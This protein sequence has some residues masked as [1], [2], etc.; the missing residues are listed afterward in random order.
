M[1]DALAG[2]QDEGDFHFD[3]SMKASGCS[4]KQNPELTC[5]DICKAE[6]EKMEQLTMARNIGL[7][8]SCPED[9]VE[10]E[11]VYFQLRLLQYT[12]ARK[13]FAGMS[14]SHQF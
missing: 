11:L 7:L 4:S 6:K 5:S 9:E 10:G 13:K 2:P 14:F 12:V 8:E 3:E 1:D